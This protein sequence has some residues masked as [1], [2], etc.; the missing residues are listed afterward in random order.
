M[1]SREVVWGR[2]PP[3]TGSRNRLRVSTPLENWKAASL[4]ESDVLKHMAVDHLD[5]APA[6]LQV[7]SQRAPSKLRRRFHSSALGPLSK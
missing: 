1:V 4:S 7:V 6:T 3:E 5:N 2:R